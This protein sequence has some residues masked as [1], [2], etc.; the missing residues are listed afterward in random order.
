LLVA[1]VTISATG[2]AVDLRTSGLNGVVL[3]ILSSNKI[4]NET[5]A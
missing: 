3:D 2:I 1:R 5:A 4:K